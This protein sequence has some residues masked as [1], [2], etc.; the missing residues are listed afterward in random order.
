MGNPISG[1]LISASF[2]KVIQHY[3]TVSW[4][5]QVGYYPILEWRAAVAGRFPVL[6]K[7]TGAVGTQPRHRL[8][9]SPIWARVR[10]ESLFSY[11]ATQAEHRRRSSF[12]S[13]GYGG[14]FGTTRPGPMPLRIIH[15]PYGAG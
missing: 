4:H 8:L 11:D 2:S 6:S 3:S 1:L 5:S 14:S 12:E 7:E 10:V 9:T 13:F 15:I